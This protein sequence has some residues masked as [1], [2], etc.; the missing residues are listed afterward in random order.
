M[1]NSVQVGVIGA[2]QR[3][4]PALTQ[5]WLQWTG[6]PNLDHAQFNMVRAERGSNPSSSV[7]L[8]AR[9]GI[10]QTWKAFCDL[11]GLPE[12]APERRQMPIYLAGQADAHSAFWTA[13][14][15]RELEEVDGPVEWWWRLMVMRYRGIQRASQILIQETLGDEALLDKGLISFRNPTMNR[16]GH[17]SEKLLAADYRQPTHV[18]VSL[19]VKRSTRHEGLAFSLSEDRFRGSF[20]SKLI[21]LAVAR[22]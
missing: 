18:V 8:A 5:L 2:M 7:K 14:R 9:S 22:V 20:V 1:E 17:R 13:L 11:L 3:A 6:V 15:R 21:E 16:T 12:D 19:R 10:K 4:H